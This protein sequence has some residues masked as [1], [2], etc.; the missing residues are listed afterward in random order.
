MRVDQ[1]F[2]KRGTQL[3]DAQ[4]PSVIHSCADALGIYCEI[5]PSSAQ[6]QHKDPGSLRM[7]MTPEEALTFGLNLIAAARGSL[8]AEGKLE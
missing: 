2:N 6:I 3:I 5:H 7:H 8:L 4:T 1:N